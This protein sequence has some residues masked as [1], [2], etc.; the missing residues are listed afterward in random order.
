M[1]TIFDTLVAMLNIQ[2]NIAF[3]YKIAPSNNAAKRP[4]VSVRPSV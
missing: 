4:E 2:L 3:G 1:F